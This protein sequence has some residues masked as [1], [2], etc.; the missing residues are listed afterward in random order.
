MAIGLYDPY[1]DTIGGGEKHILSIM[2]VLAQSDPHVDIF[3]DE[4]IWDTVQER[5][6]LSFPQRPTFVP[7]IMKRHS[8]PLRTYTALKKYTHFFY[9]TD[10]SYF[11]SSAKNNYVFCMVPEKKLYR[12]TPMNRLKLRNYT[13][14]ANSQFTCSWLDRWGIFAS[15]IYPH[16]DIP[17]HTSYNKKEPIILSVGRF[18]PHL[19]TKKHDIIIEAFEHLQQHA[20]DNSLHLYLV[21]AVHSG[22]ERYVINLKKRTKNNPHIHIETNVTKKRLDDLYARARYYWHFAGYGVDET[23]Y[24]HQVEHLGITPLEAMAHKC[25]TCCY[26][27]GGPKEITT[28]GDNGYLFTD[29][30]DLISIMQNTMTNNTKR[31][32]IATHAYNYVKKH[33][34]HDVFEKNVRKIIPQTT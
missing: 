33:F 22:D 21:G 20:R 29:I 8:S 3:W 26:N 31:K 27:A 30:N 9:V 18:F 2:R 16:V 19:H 23:Q 10:G 1:L 17:A 14:I 13:F 25:V 5:F 24:P 11:F 12:M 34:S 7:A 32:N 6:P 15:Y 4:D 28:H